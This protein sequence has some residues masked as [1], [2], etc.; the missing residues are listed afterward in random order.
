MWQNDIS[1]VAS[2]TRQISTKR[3][4]VPRSEVNLGT[5]TAESNPERGFGLIVFIYY[6]KPC[7]RRTPVVPRMGEPG[8]D[9]LG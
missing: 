3:D 1:K 6:I 7:S 8:T 9:R 2:G 4:G 5:R